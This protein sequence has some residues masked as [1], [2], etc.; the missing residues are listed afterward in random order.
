MFGLRCP[1]ERALRR[2]PELLP[3]SSIEDCRE[4]LVDFVEMD[5]V[6]FRSFVRIFQRR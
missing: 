5:A 2:K 3:P 4:S 1:V 6:C